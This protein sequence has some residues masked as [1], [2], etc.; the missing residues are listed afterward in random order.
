MSWRSELEGRARWGEVCRDL[1]DVVLVG[2]HG[3]PRSAKRK[4]GFEF[5]TG[6]HFGQG[7]VLVVDAKGSRVEDARGT[8]A[9]EFRREAIARS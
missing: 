7:H 9:G 4:M 1:L 5:A 2:V 3:V 6:L 8:H